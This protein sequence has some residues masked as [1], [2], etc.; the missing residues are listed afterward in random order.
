MTTEDL[1]LFMAKACNYAQEH[2][3]DPQAWSTE[4]IDRENML[5]C[6]S[7]QMACFLAQYTVHG[8]RGVEW[9]VVIDDLIAYPMKTEDQWVDILNARAEELGGWLPFEKGP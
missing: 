4:E 7:Y 2:I 8:Y 1:V 6:V 3:D 5:Q 9:G